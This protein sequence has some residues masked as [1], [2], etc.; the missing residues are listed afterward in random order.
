MDVNRATY[1]SVL[2]LIV[3]FVFH[4]RRDPLEE[5]DVP[6]AQRRL[7][8]ESDLGIVEDDPIKIIAIVIIRVNARHPDVAHVVPRVGV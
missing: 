6:K 4:R 5:I 7:A 2:F 1:N 3:L 8:R